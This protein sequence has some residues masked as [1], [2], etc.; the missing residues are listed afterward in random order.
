MPWYRLYH[1]HKHSGHIDRAE[2]VHAADDVSA[3]HELQ[4]RVRDHPLELWLG[5]RKVVHL[6]A[7]PSMAAHFPS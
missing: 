1:L 2:D 4:H 7:V 5:R 3:I 6:D